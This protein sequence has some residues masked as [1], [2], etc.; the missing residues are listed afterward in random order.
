MRKLLIAATT[1][2]A[3]TATAVT[4]A[5]AASGIAGPY[6]SYSNCQDARKKYATIGYKVGPCDKTTKGY[7]FKFSK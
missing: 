1:A 2:I 6:K 3:L 5:V 7:Y 4:P